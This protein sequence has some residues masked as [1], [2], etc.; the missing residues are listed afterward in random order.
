MC[1]SSL[2]KELSS[3]YFPLIY[4]FLLKKA[5]NRSASLSV[6]WYGMQEVRMA[7]TVRL[8]FDSSAMLCS[9]R[10]SHDDEDVSGLIELFIFMQLLPQLPKHLRPREGKSV[11]SSQTV[12]H[13]H[14]VPWDP[15]EASEEPTALNTDN[16]L[17]QTLTGR[18]DNMNEPLHHCSL[19]V[20]LSV[21][22][23]RDSNNCSNQFTSKE[24]VN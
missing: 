13:R 2:E 17:Q 3:V 9:H 21:N 7:S 24:L 1:V 20:E 15:E 22:T 6:T 18:T 16:Q 19:V 14:P 8:D 12:C 11:S 4:V 5:D 10:C 23:V